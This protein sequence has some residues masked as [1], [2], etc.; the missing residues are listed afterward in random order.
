VEP[1]QQEQMMQL[2]FLQIIYPDNNGISPFSIAMK[3]SS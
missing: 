3:Q 1:E 2:V